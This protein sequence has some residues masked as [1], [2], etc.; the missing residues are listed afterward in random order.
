L[1]LLVVSGG[2]SFY[3]R[4]E[5]LVELLIYLAV[6]SCCVV[7]LPASF[8]FAFRVRPKLEGLE[9]GWKTRDLQYW[10]VPK[11]PKQ[12]VK[13]SRGPVG[14]I[15]EVSQ[16]LVGLGSES[17]LKENHSTFEMLSQLGDHA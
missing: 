1:E 16:L 9:E 5:L 8:R 14:R 2:C 13:S 4:L 11:I 17:M 6:V 10:Q 7:I 15:F 12:D 3:L